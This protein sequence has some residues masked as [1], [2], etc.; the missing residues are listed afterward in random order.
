MHLLVIVFL[1][2]SLP[3]EF[4][5]ATHA[6]RR[7]TFSR[8]FTFILLSYGFIVTELMLLLGSVTHYHSIRH[9]HVHIMR[10]FS[11]KEISE[12]DIIPFHHLL[13]FVLVITFLFIALAFLLSQVFLQ[14]LLKNLG[15]KSDSLLETEIRTNNPWLSHKTR[16]VVYDSDQV[17]AFSFTVVKIQSLRI[18]VQDVIMLTTKIVDILDDDEIEMVLAHEFSHVSEYDTRYAHLIY[19]V[20]TI[21]F[22]D[23]FM[24]IFRRLI[25]RRH[26]IEAD[27]QAVELRQK[28]KTLA[29]A[30]LK[31]VKY[32]KNLSVA[33]TT[34]LFGR[35]KPLILE[36]INLLIEYA[37]THGLEV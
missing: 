15:R 19:T 8:L 5:M 13:I 16:L 25:D 17:D 21:M 2:I 3:V 6:K 4:S 31:L 32:R 9:I 24:Q 34:A 14:L 28:P 11:E 36:R 12:N 10:L 33:P 26:E 30:L 23:P 18:H 22:F 35:R 29:R 37:E 27:L 1:A 7:T 20:A